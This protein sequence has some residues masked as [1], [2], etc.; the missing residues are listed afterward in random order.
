VAFKVKNN[1]GYNR[2][3]LTVIVGMMAANLIAAVVSVIDRH[4]P[5]GVAPILFLVPCLL[6]ELDL[7]GGR[8]L[9]RLGS[10]EWSCFIGGFLFLAAFPL[11]FVR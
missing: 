1:T 11:F 10:F 8:R 9:R 5:I 4:Y 3:R 2:V 7:R 6:R